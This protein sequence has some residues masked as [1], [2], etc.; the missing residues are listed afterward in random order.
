VAA[1]AGGATLQSAPTGGTTLQ[2][3]HLRAG[4][5]RALQSAIMAPLRPGWDPKS[6]WAHAHAH[7]HADVAGGG[8]GGGP[9]TFNP[10]RCAG[11][12]TV[13]GDGAVARQHASKVRRGV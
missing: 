8:G 1:A 10:S 3:Y 12:I 11:T 9:L 5:M 2:S 7:A 4:L 6:N 13:E